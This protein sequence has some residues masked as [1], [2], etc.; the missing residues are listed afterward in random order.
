MI[1]FADK[2]DLKKRTIEGLH[3]RMAEKETFYHII[4]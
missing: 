4:N 2:L 1:K 3:T